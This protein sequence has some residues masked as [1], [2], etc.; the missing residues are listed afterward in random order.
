MTEQENSI[1][2]PGYRILSVLGRG[3][4]AT[5]YLAV[6]ESLDRQIAL[7]IMS[8]TLGADPAFS[9]RFLREG[10]IA[11]NLHH[12]NLVPVYDVGV[13]EGMHYI[14]MQYQSGGS[15]DSE[16][17][18]GLSVEQSLAITKDIAKALG[19]A[20]SK[21]FVHRDVKP[22]NILFNERGQAVLVDFG[23]A[24]ATDASNSMTQTGSILGTPYYMSPEQARGKE[25]DGRADIYSLGILL[26]QM[27]TGEVP[28]KGDD[29]VAVCVQH[30]NSPIPRLPEGFSRLQSLVDRMLAKDPQDRFPGT[31]ELLRAIESIEKNDL[32]SELSEAPTLA[33]ISAVHPD[34]MNTT[35][36]AATLTDFSLITDK[37]QTNISPIRKSFSS[38]IVLFASI[39]VAA[40]YVGAWFY[41]VW[42]QEKNVE[43]I[44]ALI[45]SGAIHSSD[46]RSAI[47]SWRTLVRTQRVP[48][49]SKILIL[50]N[51]VREY[52]QHAESE[53]A[54][55]D[56]V[57]ANQDMQ[58]AIDLLDENGDILAENVLHS[59]EGRLKSLRQQLFEQES[60]ALQN[61]RLMQLL[62]SKEPIFWDRALI[63]AGRLAETELE[64]DVSEKIAAVPENFRQWMSSMID[65]GN[66]S[67]ARETLT[68][69]TGAWL[70]DEA[71]LVW[72]KRLATPPVES[73]AA[74]EE[75]QQP[76]P[77]RKAAQWLQAGMD[78]LQQDRL[79]KPEGQSALD[80]FE[81]ILRADP[82]NEQA[83]L[84]MTGLVKRLMELAEQSAQRGNSAKAAALSSKAQGI[85]SDFDFLSEI[86]TRLSVPE[87]T[88]SATRPGNIKTTRA[89]ATVVEKLPNDVNDL[90]VMA[91]DAKKEGDLALAARSLRKIL[92]I[93]EAHHEAR[94]SLALLAS[95][96]AKRVEYFLDKEDLAEA[97]NAMGVA[98]L[99][100]AQ[101]SEVRA[102]QRKLK[103]MER[104]QTSLSF[105]EKTAGL[106]KEIW[107]NKARASM[108]A[109]KDE[110][111]AQDLTQAYFYYLQLKSVFP[112]DKEFATA[113]NEVL[114]EMLALVEASIARGELVE[115]RQ[116]LQ[117]VR[118]VNPAFGNADQLARTLDQAS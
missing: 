87:E 46:D 11:A 12:P 89:D 39:A 38:P 31:R 47:I 99:V 82:A 72:Q 95:S 83:K 92:E 71:R 90:M 109:Y 107:F 70:D 13:H 106:K 23:I 111:R 63:E 29:P 78:A 74:R 4:M 75:G 20:H 43:E 9:D 57:H 73:M 27:L 68:A 19:Y 24:R 88:A 64:S 77:E 94:R 17:L 80:Y 113:M 33:G 30:L 8:A 105:D 58:A 69:I 35:G 91:D 5:V 44:L 10:R 49:A 21:G 104:N 18:Q 15:L 41:D 84:G 40:V 86:D 14:A 108:Q 85:Q 81:M 51:L 6:Q 62:E 55:G 96:A 110:R 100:D 42:Q 22:D 25:I 3:G 67:K 26:Y 1:Q 56:E 52:I 60:L 16:K 54:R 116:Y 66:V 117:M 98:L 45:H 37:T 76:I 28:Y 36:E 97:R 112:G 79:T 101:A 34:D 59:F 65:N 53:L 93:E 61:K 114:H 2:I 32:Y 118:E 102:V 48:Q 7:K 50:S 103:R 115:A